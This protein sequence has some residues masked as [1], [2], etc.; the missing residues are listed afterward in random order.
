MKQERKWYKVNK[1]YTIK[2]WKGEKYVYNK[3]KKNQWTLLLGS[4]TLKGQDR[5]EN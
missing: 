1:I 3:I 2:T 4:I 5:V